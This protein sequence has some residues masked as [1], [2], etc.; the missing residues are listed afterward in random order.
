M[1]AHKKWERLLETRT[2]KIT[3]EKSED[4]LEL[5][6]IVKLPN[7]LDLTDKTIREYASCKYG[8]SVK[9]WRVWSGYETRI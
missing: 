9:E 7:D 4:D 2:V 3:W 6:E 8:V 1:W 5:P